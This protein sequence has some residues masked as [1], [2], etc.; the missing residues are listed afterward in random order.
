MVKLTGES[1]IAVHL[2]KKTPKMTKRKRKRE[3]C[4]WKNIKSILTN[5]EV[6]N[7]IDFKIFKI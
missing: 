7:K 2:M 6:G 4:I 5:K 1:A 3:N